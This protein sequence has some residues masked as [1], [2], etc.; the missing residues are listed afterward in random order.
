MNKDALTAKLLDLAEGRETPETW[1]SWWDEHESELETLL[2]RGEFLK[3]KPCRHGFQWV[4]VFGSQKGAIAILE[5]SGTAF[6]ASNLYQERYL[7]ELE[8]FC[9]E[10]ERVQRKKQKEFKTSNP[11]LF[12][13]YPKFSKALAKVLDPSDEIKP[14]ATEEQIRNQES[15]LDFTLPAQVREFFLLTAGIQASVGVT[16]DLSDLFDLTIHGEWYCVLGEFW[17][18]ADGDQL[19]LR[20]GEETIWYYAHEQDKIKRLC[21]DMTELLEKKLAR[22]LNEQ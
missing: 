4:P 15:V 19:L 3:L 21:S 20:P 2:N 13:R 11:E 5:K 8:A 10:Q 9:K 16:I 12:G 6:E 7:A 1:R 18:E 22:Y 17:K 14:A